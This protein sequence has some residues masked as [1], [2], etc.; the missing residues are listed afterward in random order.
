MSLQR[1][2]QRPTFA[3]SPEKTVVEGCQLL[4]EN[5]VGCLLVE[6][7]DKLCGIVTD[8]DIALRVT[9]QRKDPR[10][11]RM[12]EVMT[13]NPVRISVDRSLHELTALMHAHHVRRVPIVDKSDKV[14]GIVTLDDL[15][16]LLGDEMSDM[17]KT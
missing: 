11:T 16:A 5:N 12:R 17:G 1:F 7:W 2:C 9:G 4:Q 8:R 15:M 3:I 6:E 10:Q 13:P 14:I